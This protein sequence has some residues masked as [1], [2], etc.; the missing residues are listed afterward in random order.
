MGTHN[1]Y[2]G[3]QI[4]KKHK[5][6]KRNMTFSDWWEST[7]SA[8]KF[9]PQKALKQVK[10]D[11]RETSGE[12]GFDIIFLSLANEEMKKLSRLLTLEEVEQLG[13]RARIQSRHSTRN[14]TKGTTITQE[15]EQYTEESIPRTTGTLSKEIYHRL[16]KQLQ[17]IK[18]TTNPLLSEGEF[19]AVRN[20]KL[21]SSQENIQKI[22]QELSTQAKARGVS[23]EQ[24]RAYQ[25]EITR[26]TTLAQKIHARLGKNIPSLEFK[27][28]VTDFETSFQSTKSKA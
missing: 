26:W 23:T 15:T 24:Q 5:L 28:Y 16:D 25:L 20:L 2:L 7:F 10:K 21:K 12:Q 14:N 9:N 4:F 1:K 11:Y 22:I 13:H 27:D 19:N 6:S 17:I 18:S 3:A 8:D